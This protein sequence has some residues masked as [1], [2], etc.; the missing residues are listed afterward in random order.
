MDK[1]L[2]NET[3]RTRAKYNRNAKLYNV[4]EFPMELLWY[5]RWRKQLFAKLRGQRILEVGV[6]TGKNLPYYSS[7]MQGIGLDL[8]DGMLTRAKQ[9]IR[10]GVV[11]LVQGDAQQLPF[12]DGAFDV[13][14]ATFVFCSVP[15]PVHGLREIR[16]V[17]ASDGRLLLLEHVL[18]ENKVLASLFNRANSFTVRQAGVHINRRTA[19]SIRQAGFKI[20]EEKNLLSTVFK[21]FVVKK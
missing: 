4:L 21:L 14:I 11:T 17:L 20:R 8:S 12:R 19:E 13:A 15:D 3:A 1:K 7:E 18:P 5:S 2:A 16:R 10:D 9:H 6:G